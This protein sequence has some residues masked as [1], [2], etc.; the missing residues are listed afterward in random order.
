MESH[1]RTGLCLR[2]GRTHRQAQVRLGLLAVR[3]EVHVGRRR[4][5]HPAAAEVQVDF[6]L[7]SGVGV[8]VA[9]V[10]L[11]PVRGEARGRRDD[12]VW[13]ADGQVGLGRRE[14]HGVVPQVGVPDDEVFAGQCDGRR[15]AACV[16]PNRD[17]ESVRDVPGISQPEREVREAVGRRCHERLRDTLARRDG[18]VAGTA[19]DGVRFERPLPERR[20]GHAQERSEDR[21]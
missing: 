14:R 9:V 7:A 17:A 6:R 16:K 12:P 8:R 19:D 3:H 11:V 21:A 13:R 5:V 2:R 20:G 1:G 15:H 18:D 10:P 4:R